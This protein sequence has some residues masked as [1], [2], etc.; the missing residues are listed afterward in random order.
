MPLE[1]FIIYVYCCVDDAMQ[2]LFSSPLRTR[3]FAPKLSD[4]EVVTMEI[5]GEF[6]GKDCDKTIW[7]Y[8]RNHWHTWFPNLGS[9]SNFVKQ[10]A[11]L[12]LVKKEIQQYLV[13]KM[14][15]L[16]DSVHMSDG[17]PMPVCTIT[18][19]S[20]NRSFLGETAY[21]YCASKDEHYYGFEGH[22]VVNFDGV[23]CGYT[24]AAA[25]IDERDVLQDM[26]DGLSGLMISDK[27]L[28]RP[29]LKAELAKQ[30]LNLQTPLRK[31]MKDSRPK[32]V[33]RL[34][35]KI[36]RRVETV[37][38]QLSEHFHIEK[39][40]A[41]DLWHLANRVI[42]KILAHTVGVFL[43]KLLGHPPLHLAEL[44]EI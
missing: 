8:F 41:R 18:R 30:G 14:G 3:G 6:M 44:V 2:Q 33:V 32:E 17:F 10:S 11:N 40:R 22:L 36:R 9:R 38:S 1:D 28:I 15:A 35:M 16:A 43:N 20:R 7:R 39:V 29:E 31:N 24:V 42:R 25:N 37:I 23:I 5:V 34:F 21:G 19:A 27:G 4:A 13:R 26:T 12:W